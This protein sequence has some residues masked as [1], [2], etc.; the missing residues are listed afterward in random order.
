MPEELTAE[1]RAILTLH[2]VPGLGPKL[3]MALLAHFGSAAAILR[4]PSTEL[5][6]IPFVGAEVAQAITRALRETDVDA[7]LRRME[8]HRVGALIPGEPDYPACLNEIPARPHLLYLRGELRPGDARAIAIVGSRHCTSYGRRMAEKLACELVRSGFTIISGLA[9]GI[10][11]VAHRAALDAHGRTIAVLAGGL[12]RIYPP[13]HTELAKEIEASGALMSEA[14]M[15]MEPM[16]GMF[17]AR[18]RLISGLARGVVIVEAAA[19]SGALITAS[20]AAEQGRPVFAVPGAIDSPLSDG[21]H[22]LLR[23]GAI[24]L[25]GVEDI[26]EEL[27]GVRPIVKQAEVKKPENLDDIQA[28]IWESLDGGSRHVDELVRML[29]LPVSQVTSSLL[30]LEMRKLVR[31]LPGNQYE[32]HA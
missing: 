18:N 3:T 20:H 2:L 28:R 19:R 32:R 31:R 15:L 12:A 26:L 30:M 24:L 1:K 9:R 6:Q 25:R 29:S 22:A 4:A 11:G 7:E 23:Q 17:P 14:P 5:Q 27:E 21:T 10:D 13:E 8:Q 16:A